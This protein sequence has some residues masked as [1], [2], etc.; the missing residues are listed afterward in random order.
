MSG[1]LNWGSWF[2]LE[3]L[4]L[5]LRCRKPKPPSISTRP[6]PRRGN[7]SSLRYPPDSAKLGGQPNRNPDPNSVDPL[8]LTLRIPLTLKDSPNSNPQSLT[9]DLVGVG[10]GRGRNR[11]SEQPRQREFQQRCSY[12]LPALPRTLTLPLPNPNPNSSVGD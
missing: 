4:A 1:V 9:D 3:S 2:L 7:S 5:L 10:R 6:P 12:A 11:T 8:T